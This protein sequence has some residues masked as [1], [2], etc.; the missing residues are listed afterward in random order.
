MKYTLCYDKD[1]GIIKYTPTEQLNLEELKELVHQITEMATLNE[2]YLLLS[3]N[4][5][6]SKSLEMTEI[7]DLT[8]YYNEVP[9]ALNF[10]T[11]ILYCENN[12]KRTL[13]FYESLCLTAGYR[14][15]LFTS[16]E[17]A[18]KWL[19]SNQKPNSFKTFNMPA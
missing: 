2:C 16:E 3:D 17:E 11:A 1:N 4:R 6:S 9:S 18:L 15:K 13:E 14:V 19:L 10:K 8:K 7:I 12:D 5:F